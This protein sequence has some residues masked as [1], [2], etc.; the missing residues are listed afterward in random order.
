MHQSCYSNG[1]SYSLHKLFIY[2]MDVWVK[3]I[4]K[5]CLHFRIMN[6]SS[7]VYPFCLHPLNNLQVPTKENLVPHAGAHVHAVVSSLWNGNIWGFSLQKTRNMF[8]VFFCLC[9]M[10]LV[11]NCPICWNFQLI[12]FHCSELSTLGY[13]CWCV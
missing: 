4:T 5:V 3:K 11:L 12:F 9:K 8:K 10:F 7:G 1:L 6:L 2:F 13:G